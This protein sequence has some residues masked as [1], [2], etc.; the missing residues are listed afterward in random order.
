MGFTN[1]FELRNLHRL[2]QIKASN[3]TTALPLEGSCC[4]LLLHARMHTIH[5]I[6]LLLYSKSRG[7]A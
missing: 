5:A 1:V 6:Q 7:A 3:E 2:G 4:L